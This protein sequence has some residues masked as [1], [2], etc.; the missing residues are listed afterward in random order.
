MSDTLSYLTTLYSSSFGITSTATSLLDTLYGNSAGASG[1]TNAV[2]ALQTAESTEAKQVSITAEQPTV[3][4]AISAFTKAV[5][6]ATSVDQL[7]ANPDVMNVLLTASGMSDQIGYT[8]LAQKTLT[9]NLSDPNSLVNQLTDTRWKTLAETYNFATNGLS[10]IQ[11]PKVLALVSNAYAQAT[12]E[13]NEDSVTPGLSNAL[14]F[15]SQA[16]TIRSVDQILGDPT[17]F[18]VVT[19]ALGVP[20]QIVF[21]DMNA[22]E[23]AITS[24]LDISQLRNPT[25]VQTFAERYL[26]QNSSTASASTSSA[27]LTGLAV[28]AQGILV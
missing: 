12:W 19:T 7:L 9:S 26:I 23:N 22:E 8:A 21:Q 20:E 24:R 13:S 28:Q 5:K 25:F 2:E 17:L 10:A 3:K 15:I 14:Y 11:N 16:P 18:N 6:S 27:D 1:S 4:S